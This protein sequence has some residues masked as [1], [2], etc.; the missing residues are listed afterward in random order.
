MPTPN[1][2]GAA[3]PTVAETLTKL[4]VDPKTGLSPADVQER[5]KKYGPNA[6][7]EKQKST[8]RRF[9]R[10]FLGAHPMDDRGRGIDG[11]YRW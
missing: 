3:V 6:L 2:T 8:F 4:G 1:A 7:A 11:V 10:I 9:A 5:L